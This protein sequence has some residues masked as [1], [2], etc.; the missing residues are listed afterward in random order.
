M[1]AGFG[2]VSTDRFYFTPELARSRTFEFGWISQIYQSNLAL[3][4][5]VAAGL[6][7]YFYTFSKQGEQRKYDARELIKNNRLFSF[8]SQLLDNVF[9]TLASGVTV[10]TAYEVL[11]MWAFANGYL[12]HL[13]WA[14]NPFPFGN[15]AII[16]ER[17]TSGDGGG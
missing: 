12:S 2:A 5:I 10:W 17:T 8:N 1:A 6:H 4:I 16:D 15:P 13:N 3:M 9:W 14:N 7:L 11:M